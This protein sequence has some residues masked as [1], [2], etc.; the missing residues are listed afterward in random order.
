MVNQLLTPTTAGM[1]VASTGLAMIT[2]APDWQTKAIGLVLTIAGLLYAGYS[3]RP[4]KVSDQKAGARLPAPGGGYVD[5]KPTVQT[6]DVPADQ[7][8]LSNMQFGVGR[9]ERPKR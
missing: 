7:M 3:T 2:A 6:P 9:D 1:A 5:A 8:S 4:M